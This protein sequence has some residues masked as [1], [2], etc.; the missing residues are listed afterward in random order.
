MRGTE[1]DIHWYVRDGLLYMAFTEED[2]VGLLLYM[3][4]VMKKMI[5]KNPTAVWRAARMHQQLHDNGFIHEM[6]AFDIGVVYSIT[7]V[8]TE[9]QASF[10]RILNTVRSCVIGVSYDIVAADSMMKSM[11]HILTS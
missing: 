6:D 7:L 4:Q 5:G 8:S 2:R 10:F 11:N 1:G 9:F 3:E